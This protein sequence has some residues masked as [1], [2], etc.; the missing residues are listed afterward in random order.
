MGDDDADEF[1]FVLQFFV[2][3]ISVTINIEK[4]AID[5]LENWDWHFTAVWIRHS[6]SRS[7]SSSPICFHF[8]APSGERCSTPRLV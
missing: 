4:N 8:I 6:S 1:T 5:H 7:P 3:L 2:S